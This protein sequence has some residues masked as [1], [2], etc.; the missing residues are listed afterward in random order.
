VSAPQIAVLQRAVDATSAGADL[1]LPE[2]AVL[3]GVCK[4]IDTL[5][6]LPIEQFHLCVLSVC[7]DGHVAGIQLP[8][9]SGEHAM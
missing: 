1:P 3:L 8:Y 2:L 4:F 5:A 6:L 9:F 7:R